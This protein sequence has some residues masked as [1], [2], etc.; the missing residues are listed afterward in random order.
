MELTY[1][2]GENLIINP[3]IIRGGVPPANVTW[4]HDNII[5]APAS[6]SRVMIDCTTGSLSVNGLQGKDS[7]L[8]TI[9]LSNEIGTAKTSVNI[10]INC[11]RFLF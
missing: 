10:I 4:L 11:E 8:Y 5:L 6:D 7:G 2:S 3:T 9:K 1:N